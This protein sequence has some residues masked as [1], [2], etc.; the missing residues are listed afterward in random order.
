[1]AK[2]TSAT[3]FSHWLGTDPYSVQAMS[4]G[5]ALAPPG[6]PVADVRDPQELA[7]LQAKY[8]DMSATPTNLVSGVKKKGGESA[9][10]IPTAVQ[11]QQLA[12]REAW[13]RYLGDTSEAERP[14]KM[15]AAWDQL[16][17]QQPELLKVMPA[18]LY[19]DAGG[20]VAELPQAGH[21]YFRTEA[22]GAEKMS[23]LDRN[24]WVRPALIAAG[25]VGAVALP[26]AIGASAAAGAGGAGSA[27]AAGTAGTA[28]TIAGTGAAGTGATGAT[29]AGLSSA[30]LVRYG[31]P[32]AG[33]LVGSYLQS[34]AAGQAS[35]AQQRYLEEALA[36]EKEKDQYQRGVDAAAVTREGQRYDSYQ[37]RIAPFIASGTA[38]NSRMAELLGLPAGSGG[39]RSASRAASTPTGPIPKTTGNLLKDLASANALAYGGAGHTDPSYWARAGYDK[40][41]QYFYEKML[42]KDA[43]GADVPTAGPWAPGGARAATPAASPAVMAPPRQGTAPSG[44]VGGGALVQMRGPDGSI[45]AVPANQVAHY[46]QR[47]ATL[48]QGA[49]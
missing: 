22:G 42:G 28:A 12:T 2:E 36:Y 26:A 15:R 43:G 41:P 31:L 34:R 29:L 1:M 39:S 48:L 37:G 46:Q 17:Q 35:D 25:G 3:Q 10:P 8:P 27:S 20:A 7:R 40:D 13:E 4:N 18:N 47:G 9:T 14:A 49:A 5:Y 6:V 21:D 44:P 24:P 30:E 16:L 38:A 45:K 19:R 32:V 23:F 33:N 11:A